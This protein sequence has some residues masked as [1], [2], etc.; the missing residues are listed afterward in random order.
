MQKLSTKIKQALV[1]EAD[2]DQR[3]R[4]AELLSARGFEV[5]ACDSLEAGRRFFRRHPLVLAGEFGENGDAQVF[6]DYVRDLA[7][8]SQPYVIRMLS[9]DDAYTKPSGTG[10]NDVLAKPVDEPLFELKLK[11]AQLWLGDDEDVVVK[12][13]KKSEVEGGG[14]EESQSEENEP[15]PLRAAARKKFGA[16]ELESMRQLAVLV[17]ASPSG[18]ALFDSEMRYLIANRKWKQAFALEDD[19]LVG[20]AHHDIFLEVS[21]DWERLCVDCLE[22]GV[23]QTGS[24]LVE[25]ANGEREWVRWTMTPW[26]DKAREED[27][28]SVTFESIPDPRLSFRQEV[29]ETDSDLASVLAQ[30]GAAPVVVLDLDGSIVRSNRKAREIGRWQPG[31]ARQRYADIFLQGDARAEFVETFQHFAERAERDGDFEFAAVSIDITEDE[32]G[33]TRRLAWHNFPRRAN[34]GSISGMIRIGVD[35]REVSG[36]GGGL[37]G[38]S[39]MWM[40]L[41]PQPFFKVRV[42]DG[43]IVSSNRAWTELRGSGEG[44]SLIDAVHVD[45]RSRFEDAIADLRDS[46]SRMRLPLRLVDAN[47]NARWMRM[48]VDPKRFGNRTKAQELIGFCEDAEAQKHLEQELASLQAKHDELLEQSASDSATKELIESDVATAKGE[49]EHLRTELSKAKAE[50]VKVAPGG[51]AA[52]PA[53]AAKV[54][55]AIQQFQQREASLKEELTIVRGQ[56]KQLT[57]ELQRFASISENAPFGLIVL[58]REGRVLYANP[59]HLSV[60]GSDVRKSERFE[61]WLAK[62][63]PDNSPAAIDSMILAWREEVWR[64]QQTRLFPVRADDDTVHELEFRPKMVRDGQFLVSIFDVTDARRSEQALSSSEAKF[65]ALF[66]DAGVPIALVDAKGQVFDANS[67]LEKLL[68]HPRMDILR[69]GIEDFVH[70]ADRDVRSIL[71]GDLKTSHTP[72]GSANVRLK[73]ASEKEVM[74]EMQITLVRNVDGDLLF[75]A[76]F[77][78]ELGASAAPASD[79]AKTDAGA[80]GAE[81]EVAPEAMMIFDSRGVIGGW[82]PDRSV[83]FPWSDWKKEEVVGKGVLDVL[84][85]MGTGLAAAVAKA[86]TD[87][88]VVDHSF[89]VDG[90]IFV[91]RVTKLGDD[92]SVLSLR[93]GSAPSDKGDAEV[94]AD[95]NALRQRDAFMSMH[96][97]VVMADLKGRITDWN[98]GA[99]RMFGYSA[100]EAVDKGLYMLYSPNDPKTFKKDFTTGISSDRRWER[101]TAFFRKDGSEG[102]CEAVFVPAL[103]EKGKAIGLVGVNRELKEPRVVEVEVPVEKVVEVPA[104]PPVKSEA[105]AAPVSDDEREKLM[106]R[107]RDN[108]TTIKTLMNLQMRSMKDAGALNALGASQL[109]VEALSILQKHESVNGNEAEIDFGGFVREFVQFLLEEIGPEETGIEVHLNVKNLVLSPETATPLALVLNELLSNSL[110]HAFTGRE[111]GIIAI[112]S[113]LGTDEGVLVVKDDGCGL[114]DWLQIDESPGLGLQIVHALS[115]QLGGGVELGDGLETEFHVRF[116]RNF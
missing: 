47:R 68:G 75:S 5:S 109:R 12:E 98:Q 79:E 31:R 15:K 65:R 35:P 69:R 48:V 53:A 51:P 37:S 49:I 74:T 21:P 108:V 59:A 24:E 28:M 76:Y 38:D 67:A 93:P 87:G 71:L 112:S 4:V 83:G 107:M 3:N 78:R 73:G 80:T 88:G 16:D 110:K 6:V 102:L 7:G 103:N 56:Q 26:S 10:V 81:L 46:G 45:D 91:G 106:A 84:P 14:D 52:D 66:Q 101:E 44:E 96:D 116:K 89:E 58:D 105:P 90:D 64:K 9:G 97:G 8:E 43:L 95:G 22:A 82:I 55:E 57:E 2:A 92:S 32:E 19:E 39:E 17:D 63:C 25:W 18:M 13:E 34:D 54:K 61:D 104:S 36:A 41:M 114:P 99:E 86:R 115:G 111:A 60:V 11:A 85:A 50:L 42:A 23:P 70:E 100:E 62:H 1:I 72:S 94:P 20:R 30:S 40:E 33:R 29:S 77:F 113:S 27:G